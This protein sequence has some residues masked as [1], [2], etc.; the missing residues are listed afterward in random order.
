MALKYFK[1]VTPGQRGLILVDKSELYKGK[2]HKP[3]LTKHSSSGGRNNAGRMTM[4]G[5]GGGAK[6]RYRVVDFKRNKDD[7]VGTVLRIEYDPNR[8]AFIALLKYEDDTHTYIIA[9]K[10]MKAGD[11]VISGEKVEIKPGNTMPLRNI[12]VG[13]K[14]HNVELRPGKGGQLARS[15]GM[16]L[17]IMGRDQNY[18]L[19][20]LKSS[21]VRLIHERC[22]ATIGEISNADH[23]N[24]VLSKAGRN[25]WRG[26]RPTVRGVAKNPVDHPHGGGEGKTS[27]GRHPVTPW[28]VSTKGH[29]TRKNTKSDKFIIRRRNRK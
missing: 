24:E 2:P 26:I 21:E 28:G 20:R 29:R 25:R 5:I 10:N 3:L 18:I 4:R 12:P 7:V 22:R 14:V 9:T 1:P 8:S 19:I 11:T 16:S 6:R 23:Q 13:T 17:Q 15:A 27:G